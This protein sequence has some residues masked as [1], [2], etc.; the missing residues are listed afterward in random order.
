MA[1][2]N[3]KCNL[4]DE[5]VCRQ[6]GRLH[7]IALLRVPAILLVLWAHFGGLWTEQSNISWRF[8]EIINNDINKPLAIYE[9]FGFFGVCLF[10]IISGFII[11]YVAQRETVK[12]FIIKRV[13]RIFPALLL[14][15]TIYWIFQKVISSLS[16]V[17]NYWSQFSLKDWFLDATLLNYFFNKSNAINGV[18]WSLIVEVLFY[19]LVA[20]FFWFIKTKPKIALSL[21]I[22]V[23]VLNYVVFTKSD[24]HVNQIAISISYIPY[25]I[26]G[27][28]LYYLWSNKITFKWF[29]FFNI[30]NYYL[31]IKNI[32]FFYPQYYIDKSYGVSLL[33][34]YLIFI[35]CML[36]NDKLKMNRFTTAVSE[37]SYSLYINHM[38]YGFFIL[39]LMYPYVQRQGYTLQFIIAVA[40]ISLVSYVKYRFIE[41]TFISLGKKFAK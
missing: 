39:S 37:M 13:L 12:A 4:K 25:L 1:N 38:P 41:K 2:I 23:C 22:Y 16:G 24:L 3:E 31:V 10:F 36:L 40:V 6:E 11:T 26:F 21:M 18:T 30:I 19:T 34:A 35:V 20:L 8:K 14:S 5:N 33:Y 32:A 29:L 28:I 17:P 27:Q 9:N 15:T 7:F